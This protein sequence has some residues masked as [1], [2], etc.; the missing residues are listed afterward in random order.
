MFLFQRD[1]KTEIGNEVYLWYN[2]DKG[3]WRLSD[4]DNF[5]ARKKTC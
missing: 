2:S 1:Q 4:G 3:S 5:Q